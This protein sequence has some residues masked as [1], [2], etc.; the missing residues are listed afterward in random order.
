MV[1]KDVFESHFWWCYEQLNKLATPDVGVPGYFRF[2]TLLGQFTQAELTSL[3]APAVPLTFSSTSLKSDK[4]NQ[5]LRPPYQ[6]I[7]C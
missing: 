6:L 3:A 4:F 5:H 7:S 2:L 1:S